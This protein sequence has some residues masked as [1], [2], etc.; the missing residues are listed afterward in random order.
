[1]R[2]VSVCEEETKSEV[3]IERQSFRCVTSK[4]A[5]E[6]TDKIPVLVLF[7]FYLQE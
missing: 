5:N 2:G 4:T 6:N 7:I 3:Y 1:M